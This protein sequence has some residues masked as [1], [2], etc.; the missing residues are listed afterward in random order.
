MV[1]KDLIYKGK[2]KQG[3]IFHFKDFYSFTYDWLINEDFDLVEK[4]Y[5]EKVSG[6]AK[7][8][9]II[10]EGYKKISDYFQFVFKIRWLILGMKDIEVQ[11]EGKKV[12]MNSG[13][14]EINFQAVLEKDYE[15]RWESKPIFKFLRGVYDK[16]IIRNRIDQYEDKIV[17]EILELIDQS[18]A[19]LALESKV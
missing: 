13:V 11:R 1:E 2:I 15:D 14:L 8:I 19:F 18:K 3:G 4:K 7:E 10:W 9:E 6:D 5:S 12:K 16:Y 17:G